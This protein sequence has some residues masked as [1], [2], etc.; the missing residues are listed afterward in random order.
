[1]NSIYTILYIILGLG[2]GIL[3]LLAPPILLGF[4]LR[5]AFRKANADLV[6][7]LGGAIVLMLM[8]TMSDFGDSFYKITSNMLSI[9]DINPLIGVIMIVMTLLFSMAFPFLMVR[10]G[11][12]MYD[13]FRMKKSKPEQSVPGYP[14][15]GVGSPEP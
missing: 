15:Q 5:I 9:W 2:V 10:I 14:P 11:V 12:N 8:T 4:T 7:I 6:S 3:L 13:R 1:M